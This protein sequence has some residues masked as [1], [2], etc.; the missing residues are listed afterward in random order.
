MVEDEGNQDDEK[1]KFTPEGE[2]LGYIS[3]EQARLLAMQTARDNPGNYG[4]RF[5]RSRM[6]FDVA[7]Q[8]DGED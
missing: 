6:V 3:L 5:S 2:T 4:R 8:E 7:E 1:Q